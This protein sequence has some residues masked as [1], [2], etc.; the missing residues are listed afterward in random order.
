[1]LPKLQVEPMH[2]ELL[3]H[4]LLAQPC[5]NACARLFNSRLGQGR[6]SPRLLFT[7]LWPCGE[8]VN[9]P[10]PH[11]QTE[12]CVSKELALQSA[13]PGQQSLPRTEGCEASDSDRRAL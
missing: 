2:F 13:L 11:E 1:M 12:A 9:V 8:A 4:A 7:L 3:L 5:D 6:G 10:L